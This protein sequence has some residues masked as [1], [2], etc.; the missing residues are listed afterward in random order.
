MH[1]SGILITARPGE[2]ELA[3]RSVRGKGV[4]VFHEDRERERFIAVLEGET[5][6]TEAVLFREIL[7]LPGVGDVSLV[8]SQEDDE[9]TPAIAA[10]PR[11]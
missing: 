8:V 2:M 3:L 10:D 11:G 9:E 5:V 7:G 4:E 1:Y 6:E